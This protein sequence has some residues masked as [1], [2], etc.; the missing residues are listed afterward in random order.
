MVCS[1]IEGIKVMNRRNFLKRIGITCAAVVVVPA[2]LVKMRTGWENDVGGRWPVNAIR[3]KRR[4]RIH[5]A[6]EWYNFKMFPS[7]IDRLKYRAK[8]RIV[9]KNTKFI[10]P[11]RR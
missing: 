9:L 11:L 1:D 2:T 8:L 3:G 5:I 10:P 7:E 4:D 6:G